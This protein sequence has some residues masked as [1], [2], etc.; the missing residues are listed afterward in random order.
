MARLTKTLF[1][2]PPPP[3]FYLPLSLSLSPCMTSWEY[4]SCLREEN[5][6]E[7]FQRGNTIQ[8][9]LCRSKPSRWSRNEEGRE[10]S[11]Q[12]LMEEE[13]CTGFQEALP[14]SVSRAGTCEAGSVRLSGGVATP[15]LIK[16]A[17]EV[18]KEFE[19][20]E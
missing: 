13:A 14:T 4:S 1:L 10:A 11:R 3:P 5:V 2:L 17:I 12:C 8:L 19:D 18:T 16:T 6:R 15:C 9:R 7:I 20:S